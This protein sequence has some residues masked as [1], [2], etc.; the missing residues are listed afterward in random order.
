M[1]GPRNRMAPLTNVTALIA[2]FVVS[3]GTTYAVDGLSRETAAETPAPRVLVSTTGNESE[4]VRTIPIT[5]Q[6]GLEKRV[7]MSM[8]PQEVPDFVPG[9]R[10]KVTA[11]VQFTVNCLPEQRQQRRCI[12]PAYSYDPV[13]HTSLVL[14][15]GEETTGGRRA[16]RISPTKRNICRQ[17]LPSRE[18]HCVV[19]F[20]EAGFTLREGDSPPC[21]LDS[22]R[23]KLVAA[24][25]HPDARSGHRL[26]VGGL[27]ATGTIP[28]DRGR[29]NAIR[30]HP[31]DQPEIPALHTKLRMQEL[32]IPDL[33]KHVVYSQML[34]HLEAGEQLEV[35]GKLE[36]DIS[37]LPYNTLTSVEVILAARPEAT[38]SSDAVKRV[39][40][41]D[42]EISEQNGFN[43]TQNRPSC[44]FRKVGVMQMEQA[45]DRLLF[46]N[47]VASFGPKR[48][49]AEFGD[50]VM[51]TGRGGLGVVRFPAPLQG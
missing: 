7:V 18:H 21:P 8:E 15:D 22:C 48:A 33:Q 20:T 5:R 19:T 35:N 46:V 30:F 3:S 10:M 29:I 34:P 4:R 13:V 17:Q 42:G 36:T 39:A 27:K 11:E 38:G 45:A 51:V 50:R 2:L 47:L 37:H 32:V 6:P 44:T 14:A 25:D 49:K 43:C 26:I 9:D 1:R 24:A 41:L 16:V 31:G 40:A 23:V 12:G 28:Q